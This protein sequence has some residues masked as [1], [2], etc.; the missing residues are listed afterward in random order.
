M[1][2][3][4]LTKHVIHGSIIVQ[5]VYRD[6]SDSSVNQTGIHRVGEAV[7]LT[8]QYSDS[9]LEIHATTTIRSNPVYM[10]NGGNNATS[11]T[12]ARIYVNGQEE[13]VVQNAGTPGRVDAYNQLS[14]HG[15]NVQ[16]FHRHLPGTTNQQTVELYIS[17]DNN[18]SGTWY[19]SSSFMILKEISGS[20]VTTGTGG[21]HI[22]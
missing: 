15:V 14:L 6:L 8:P 1:A 4:K 7:S 3:T 11:S 20:G 21:T 17:R 10:G 18:N 19:S 13:Y 22:L 12:T 2:L 16:C 5:M 9:I